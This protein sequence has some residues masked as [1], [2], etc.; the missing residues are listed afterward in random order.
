[1]IIVATDSLRGYG[2][3]RIFQ[4]VRD[5][6]YDG[7]ELVLDSHDYDSQNP[8]YV[9]GLSEQYGVPVVAVRTYKN[10]TIPKTVKTLEMA[11]KIGASIV[12]IE[13][14]KLFDFKYVEWMKQDVPK[15][16]KKY[17]LSIAL[18][19]S[20]AE[21]LLGFLPGRAMSNIG[22]L[23]NF[24]EV[25][26]DTAYLYSKKID[27]MRAYASLKGTLVMIHFSNVHKGKPHSL[28]QEG[29]LPLESLLTKLKKDNYKNAISLIVDP[30]VLNVGNDEKLLATLKEIKDF[31]QK[32]FQ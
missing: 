5:A 1:M 17:K 27:L 2:L 10:S 13:P 24:K 19:N 32:F 4:F 16:R 15:L 23:K 8:E 30:R 18:K 28:P 26:L 25:C 14:P 9:R 21:T 31:Y 29:V 20:A 22:D 3:N 6:G 12:I 7:V 11:S